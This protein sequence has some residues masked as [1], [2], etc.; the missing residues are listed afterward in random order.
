[1]VKSLGIVFP[2]YCNGAETNLLAPGI[3]VF[4]AIDRTDTLL[5]QKED[6]LQQILQNEA[7][8]VPSQ[9]IFPKLMKVI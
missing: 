7:V 6:V 3:I 2:A 9:D 1:M 5:K 4:S 8:Q